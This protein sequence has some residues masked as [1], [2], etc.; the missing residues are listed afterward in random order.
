MALNR[1]LEHDQL[2]LTLHKWG[3]HNSVS[4]LSLFYEKIHS[5]TIFLLAYV[6][7]ILIAGNDSSLIQSIISDLDKSF[8]LKSLGP[9]QYFLWFEVVR[10]T[11]SLH[12]NQI[13]YTIDLLTKTNMLR[14]QVHF[15]THDSL[16]QT[17]SSG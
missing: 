10:T 12:L 1:P 3:F 17:S 7:D 9:V 2:C 8:S 4:D 11:S 5:I 13:K 14:G 16:K 6:D 15:H